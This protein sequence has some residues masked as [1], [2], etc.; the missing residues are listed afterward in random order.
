MGKLNIFD[1]MYSKKMTQE[2]KAIF[3][4]DRLFAPPLY[5]MLYESDLQALYNVATTKKYAARLDLK[6]KTLNNILAPRGFVPLH[7]GTNRVVYKFYENRH[8]VLKVGVD[9]AGTTDGYNELK[10]QDLLKPFVAKTFEVH[11]SGVSLQE[12]VVPLTSH[13]ELALV[14]DDYYNLMTKVFIGRYVM[15]DIGESY[16]MNWGIRLGFGL[17]L[18]D[19][20]YLFELD[21]AKLK[22]MKRDKLFPNQ[23]CLGE[24]DYDLGFNH[25]ICTKCG[26]QYNARDLAKDVESQRIYLFKGDGNM[27]PIKV[28]LVRNGVVVSNGNYESNYIQKPRKQKP[29]KKEANRTGDLNVR[30]TRN[31]VPIERPTEHT[32]ISHCGC[33]EHYHHEE[34]TIPKKIQFD[35]NNVDKGLAEASEVLEKALAIAEKNPDL[36]PDDNPALA[37]IRDA[38]AMFDKANKT[39]AMMGTVTEIKPEQKDIAAKEELPNQKDYD[40]SAPDPIDVAKQKESLKEEAPEETVEENPF[41]LTKYAEEAKE[42]QIEKEYDEN[43]IVKDELEEIESKGDSEKTMSI[44]ANLNPKNR[45]PIER[46]QLNAELEY[47]L[48]KFLK[49]YQSTAGKDA[50][51]SD[52]RNRT[53]ELVETVWEEQQPVKDTDKEW[54]YEY[55]DSFIKSSDAFAMLNGY[56][57]DS[58]QYQEKRSKRYTG[59]DAF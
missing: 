7:R 58:D 53:K 39:R 38:R 29:F 54:I 11:P 4:F 5:S 12:R 42:E 56:D 28:K 32:H 34:P 2:E 30:L 52:F 3:D 41:D 18:L 10:N 49:Y 57:T 48:T 37:W 16:F 27:E 33:H 20:P 31:G 51:A 46:Q 22:C 19:Y 6:Y 15:E 59:M 50:S 55:L 36:I 21:S 35:P 13:K 8:I 24:I 17:V 40:E 23:L 1:L 43:S 14:A 25:L 44:R 26:A 47:E 9:R 45:L